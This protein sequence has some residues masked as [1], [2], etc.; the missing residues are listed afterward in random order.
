MPLISYVCIHP[1]YIHVKYMEYMFNLGAIFLSG[2]YMCIIC[3]VVV[4]F[5]C[6]LS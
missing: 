4:E 6:V 3:E 2:T 1:S 5:G